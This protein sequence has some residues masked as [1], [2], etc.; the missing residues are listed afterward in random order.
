MN[1]IEQKELLKAAKQVG[2][3]ELML[4]MLKSNFAVES[5]SVANQIHKIYA[6]FKEVNNQ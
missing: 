1:A 3:Q 5:Q 4:H 6:E 2:A